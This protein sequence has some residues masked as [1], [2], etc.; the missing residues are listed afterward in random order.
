MAFQRFACDILTIILIGGTMS[1]AKDQP[2]YYTPQRATVGRENVER[3]EWAQQTMERMRKGE[4]FRYNQTYYGPADAYIEKSDDSMWM[5]QPTTRIG[6]VVGPES[7]AQCPICKEKAREASPWRPYAIDPLNRPYKVQCM[8]CKHWFP[9]N[10]YAGGDMTSGDYP[11]DGE[12]ITVEGKTYYLLRE[13]AHMTYLSG[14][15]PALRSL[16]QM[17]LLTGDNRY[18]RAGCVLLARLASEYPNHDDRKDRLHFAQYGGRS[19]VHSWKTGGMVTDLIWETF[20][21]EAT[22]L[23]YDALFPY[24]DQ[25]PEMLTFLREKGMPVA[26]GDDLRRYI[27]KYILRAGMTGLLNGDIRGNEGFHQA[28]ALAC[29]LVLDDFD[30]PSP[31]SSDM[32]EYAYHGAGRAAYMFSNGLTRDGGGHESPNYNKIKFDFIRVNQLMEQVRARHPERFSLEHY[33][34]LFAEEKARRLFDAFIDIQ[35]LDAFLPPIGDS[36][37]ISVPRR[38]GPRSYSYPDKEHLYAFDRYGHPRYARAATKPGGESLPPGELFEPYPAEQVAAAL[39]DPASRIIRRP[40]IIDGYGMAILE[41]GEGDHRR[42]ATLNYTSL[43]GHRQSDHLSLLLH[44]RGV[45]LLPDLGYPHTWNHRKTWDANSLAH[46]TVTVDETQ[47]IDDIGGHA[48]LFA[49]RDGIHV[50]SAAHD[51]YP[52][53][54]AKLGRDDAKLTDRYQRTVV[55]VD[56][57]DTRFYVVDLFTVNGGEQHDQSWHS[58]LTSPEAPALDWQAQETGTLAGPQVPMFGE[59]TDRWGRKRNDFP[60]FLRD[61]RRAPL[62]DPAVWTWNSGLPEG[63]KLHLHVVPIEGPIEVIMGRG[64]SPARPDEWFLDYLLVRRQS[65]DGGTS[66]FL[67][68]LDPAQGEPTVRGV[69]VASHVPLILQVIRED[70]IDEIEI[71]PPRGPSRR[72]APNPMGIRVRVRQGDAVQREVRFGACGESGPGYGHATIAATDHAHWRIAIES[73]EGAEQDFVPGTAVRIYNDARTAMFQVTAAEREGN[74]LWLKLDAT[75]MLAR[76]V[77][78]GAE[79]DR[80]TLDAHL[81]FANGHVDDQGR[82][83]DTGPNYFAGSWLGEGDAARLVRGAAKRGGNVVFLAEPVSADAFKDRPI[84]LWQYGVGDRIEAA[85]IAP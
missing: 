73:G 51:P 37:G 58:M 45:D 61:I 19:P 42:A 6:R 39:R 25:D 36:G 18:A 30:G 78:I 11:D 14:T 67:T 72:M 79:D 29:A 27:E 34:D 82:L 43:I 1:Y 40:R 17:Y 66:Q 64:R 60:S 35:I 75:P 77:V 48:R 74:R 84:I 44:A 7:I 21:L 80:L 62:S 52:A 5:L 41:T 32:V 16:S 4:G 56:V 59:W 46:N 12:G 63:D 20:C 54:V 65:T 76:G 22:A 47:P 26:T 38:I 49:T 70:G 55:L 10:D 9:S 81:L 3:Y 23:A 13:Y 71:H 68:V 83:K 31:N 2:T 57:D 8:Q 33:P 15:I 24:M 53:P 28:A 50:I 85:K 69:R